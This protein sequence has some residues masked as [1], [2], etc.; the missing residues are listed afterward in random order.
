[1]KEFWNDRY[2]QNE[3]TYGTEP[4]VYLK[5]KLPTFKIGKILF[6]ADGE[7]RNSVYAAQ[8]GWDVFAFDFSKTGKEKAD[9]LAM[10]KNVRI[11][12]TVQSFLKESYNPNEFDMICLTS[13][14]FEPEMKT[15]MHKRLDRYLKIG[16]HIILEA[17]SKEHR[18]INKINPSVGGPPD[19]KMMYAIEEIKRDFT[20][21]EFIELKKERINMKE[22][23][24]HNGHSSVVRFIGKK[25]A[26]NIDLI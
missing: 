9:K 23:F 7:G 17:Y 26:N 6:P 14:H 15:E 16:G 21:Y 19:E 5:E 4:N 8:L 25:K 3:F 18:A 11:N 20:N 13:V 1:M 2:N 10:S 12:F 24:G 22:G